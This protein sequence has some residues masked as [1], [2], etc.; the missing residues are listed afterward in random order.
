MFTSSVSGREDACAFVHMLMLLRG[1][2]ERLNL[3]Y[4]HVFVS[5]FTCVRLIAFV[6]L[7]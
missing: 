1:M 5:G 3:Q 4:M 7:F 2:S 6:L